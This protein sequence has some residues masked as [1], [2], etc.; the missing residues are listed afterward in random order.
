MMN[1]KWMKAYNV[2]ELKVSDLPNLS[3]FIENNLAD[4][5]F[6]IIRNESYLRWKYIDNPRMK[7]RVLNVTKNGNMV[8]LIVFSEIKKGSVVLAK[9][10]VIKVYESLFSKESG[11]SHKKMLYVVADYYRHQNRML[12]GILTLQK[13]IYH[14]CL[15]YP[16]PHSEMLSTMEISKLET[17]YITYSDQDME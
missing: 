2:E 6:H 4:V 5:D 9:A 15:I 1:S 8:G 14:P 16:R 13:A 10:N 17:G 3:N 7:C 11:L 12:D